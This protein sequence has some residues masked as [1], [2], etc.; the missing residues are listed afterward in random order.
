MKAKIFF[1]R[2]EKTT[3]LEGITEKDLKYIVPLKRLKSVFLWETAK[4]NPHRL[5]VIKNK[6]E[7][8][9]IEIEIS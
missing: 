5:G 9:G 6:L 3:K 1:N 2:K 7:K 8:A 4:I